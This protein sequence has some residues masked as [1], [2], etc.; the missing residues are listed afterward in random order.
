MPMAV[1]RTVGCLERRRPRSGQP[2]SAATAAAI[3]A[4]GPV[5]LPLPL[6]V[7]LPPPLPPPPRRNRKCAHNSTPALRSADGLRLDASTRRPWSK[8]GWTRTYWMRRSWH[9]V[10][11]LVC[12]LI[13]LGRK[14]CVSGLGASQI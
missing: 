12:G 9:A 13:V 10:R 1:V 14:P 6:L 3:A 11:V 4:A 8:F 7:T 2:P 5:A